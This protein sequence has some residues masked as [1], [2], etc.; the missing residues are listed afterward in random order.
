MSEWLNCGTYTHGIL[1]SNANK[2]TVH[3]Y[4]DLGASPGNYSEWKKSNLQMSYTMWF[5]DR[6]L[7]RWQYFINGECSSFEGFRI[8]EE[9]SGRK[10]NQIVKGKNEGF[11]CW[12]NGF[13]SRLWGQMYKPIHVIKWYRTK[14]TPDKTGSIWMAL[15]DCISVNI[16]VVI[17]V[18]TMLLLVETRKKIHGWI[19]LYYSQLNVNLQW[20][21]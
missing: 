8:W 5:F 3:T 12:W 10:K 11:W 14:Y 2:R 9:G 19:S 21:Q 15:V 20:P 7:Q 4:N 18:C 1:L 6:T 16:L 17:P 13:V